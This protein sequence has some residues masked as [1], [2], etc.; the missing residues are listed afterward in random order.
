MVSVNLF[1]EHPARRARLDA[2]G[3]LEGASGPGCDAARPS[4]GGCNRANSL[5]SEPICATIASANP[6]ASLNFAR[7][8][9][10]S[11]GSAKA[12]QMLCTSSRVLLICDRSVLRPKVLINP[13]TTS[14]GARA[15]LPASS[16]CANHASG[17]RWMSGIG[18]PVDTERA[19]VG[20][21][22]N[23]P[24]AAPPWPRSWLRIAGRV[25]AHLSVPTC[26]AASGRRSVQCAW[27]AAVAAAASKEC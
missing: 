21:A 13:R 15:P 14:S 11:P 22:A 16:K 25:E 10:V 9:V 26:P 1:D 2:V 23:A 20:G 27:S 5:A 17:C 4:P 24:S 6:L 3:Q 19:S 8:I 12:G 7:E 18:A